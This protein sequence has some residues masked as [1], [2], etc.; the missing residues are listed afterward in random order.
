M[1]I[2]LAGWHLKPLGHAN[3]KFIY[4]LINPLDEISVTRISSIE[5]PKIVANT[6]KLSIVGKAV[7]CCHL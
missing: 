4:A 2:I 6:T 7:P 3:I 1:H 5:T